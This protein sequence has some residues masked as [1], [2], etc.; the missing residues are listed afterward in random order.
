[1]KG[2]SDME[3]KRLNEEEFKELCKE[4]VPHIEALQNI[5]KKRE[6]KNLGSMTFAQ[7]G[8]VSFSVYDT[9]WEL[10][11]IKGGEYRMKHEIGLEK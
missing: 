3:A 7:D 1:M 2:E 11:R 9:G 10:S 5:L 8:Y 6:M 4:A